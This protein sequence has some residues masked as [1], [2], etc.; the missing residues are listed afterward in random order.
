MFETVSVAD[1]ISKGR[2]QVTVPTIIIFSASLVIGFFILLYFSLAFIFP[3]VML[4]GPIGALF[5]YNKAATKWQLWAFDNVRNVHELKQKAVTS[6]LMKEDVTVP[7]LFNFGTSSTADKERWLQ[8]QEKFNRPDIF[9]D[10][11]SIPPE[12][13]VYYSKAK[14]LAWLVI[15]VPIFCL[16]I[17]LLF[18]G[19]KGT[20]TY[21]AAFVMILLG[22]SMIYVFVK[23]AMNKKPQITL[24]NEG[25]GTADSPFYTWDKV[26][27]EKTI[28]SGSGKAR[29]IYLTYNYPYGS[30]RFH[31]DGFTVNRSKLNDLLRIYRGRADK[32]QRR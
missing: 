19:I 27:N 9:N 8:L 7:G 22:G 32:K 25:I 3:F 30:A 29:S 12:T 4:A 2:R 16:G 13:I 20:S 10:D 18:S 24:N 28:V 17:A 6:G 31:I 11:P 14:K 5:Y 15:F 1:A 21:V 26:S 23:D